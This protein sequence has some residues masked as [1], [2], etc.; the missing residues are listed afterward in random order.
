MTAARRAVALLVLASA[1]AGAVPFTPAADSE[2]VEKLPG[3]TDPALRAVDSL[4][5]QLAA[6]ADDAA[7]R[8]EIARR[9]F[10]LAMAQGDPRY[11]GYASAAIAPLE[12]SGSAVPRYWLIRGL[13]Q[14]YAHDFDGALASLAKAS[15]LSPAS[16]DPIAWR[17]AIHMVQANYPQAESECRRLTPFAHLL[18]ARGCSAYVQ[19]ATGQLRQ[20][21]EGL[22]ILA[23][24]EGVD[25]GLMLWVRT[26]LGEM[27]TRLQRW[28]EAENHYE[29]ALAIGITDQFLLGAFADFLLLRGR[30]AEVLELLQGWERSDVLL[31]RLALAG[32]A[33]R[34]PRTDGWVRQL[35][36]RFQA[37][38]RRGDRLHEQE[39]A[40]FALDIEGDAPAAVQLAAS[41]YT[42]QKEPRDAEI[43]LRAAL[44]AKQPK[45]AEPALQ[46]LRSSGFEDPRLAKLA[47]Q[48]K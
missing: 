5:R 16:P 28:D 38:A 10:D 45:A 2:V 7:L 26:R 40:R 21:Y 14:Q 23:L 35:R 46:W 48:L 33:T 13:I 4:R 43:L 18:M 3:A 44:A 11:V 25:P 27:A 30:P 37:A 47:E 15:Q 20:A 32:R 34:D 39:A 17:A 9:Y 24:S 1:G 41:N 31:L 42:K 8:I 22:Q 36:D 19:A 6:R 12:S 29:R